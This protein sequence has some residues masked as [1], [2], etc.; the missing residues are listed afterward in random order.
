[1]R[2]IGGLVL[3]L[4]GLGLIAGVV[5]GEQQRLSVD[6][7]LALVATATVMI[8]GRQAL[9]TL[10]T[11]YR[12]WRPI[13][14]FDRRAGDG[15]ERRSGPRDLRALQGTLVAAEGSDRAF[16][17]RLRPRLIELADHRLRTVHGIDT[18]GR[19]HTAESVLGDAAWMVDA[20]ASSRAPTLEEIERLLDRM[21]GTT[22]SR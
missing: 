10:P 16:A 4:L 7:W 13:V 18:G 2:L 17:L 8:V 3:G 14:R 11:D 19:P 5:P 15:T 6:I 20:D 12:R 9:S 21:E 1:V 22:E